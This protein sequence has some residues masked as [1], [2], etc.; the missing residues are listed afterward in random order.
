MAHIEGGDFNYE[1]EDQS[2]YDTDQNFMKD[3]CDEIMWNLI[4][5][6][7]KFVG[8]VEEVEDIITCR[9]S[10]TVLLKWLEHL[11][12]KVFS[13]TCESGV[14][15]CGRRRREMG[16]DTCLSSVLVGDAGGRCISTSSWL[17]NE[18]LF[19]HIICKITEVS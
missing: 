8:M 17:F 16:E 4:T 15:H 9:Y 6:A 2:H 7:S 1:L 13:K 10:I 11:Q 14:W 19:V 5:C 3:K 12:A 18:T